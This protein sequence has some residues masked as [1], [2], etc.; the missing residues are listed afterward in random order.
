MILKSRVFSEGGMIPAQYTC[1]GE[2][3]SPHLSWSGAPEGTRSFAVICEDP[4]AP[5]GTWV[6]WVLYDLPPAATELPDQVAPEG[7]P[8]VGGSQ[9]TNDFK[10]IGYGGPCPPGGTHRY[11]FRLYAL[12]RM[13]GLPPGA[14]RKQA[15]QAMEGHVLAE[16]RL[17]GR[18][19]R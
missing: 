12:D 11:F 17:M 14:T 1:D 4:D 18:Y 6:H 5:A 19:R 13:T 2:D 7:S 3:L 16:A 8:S 15:V 9:G 10:R